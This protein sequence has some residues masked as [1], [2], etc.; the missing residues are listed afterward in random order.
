MPHSPSTFEIAIRSPTIESHFYPNVHLHV[1]AFARNVHLYV[2]AFSRNGRTSDRG[3][4]RPRF[5][6]FR[7]R[8]QRRL[9]PGNTL[10]CPSRSRLGSRSASS[11]QSAGSDLSKW[12]NCHSTMNSRTPVIQGFSL[13]IMRDRSGQDSS[14]C[15]RPPQNPARTPAAR[16]HMHR[17]PQG[18]GAESSNRRQDRQR[19]PST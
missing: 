16:R 17:L 12:P 8:T 7:L 19:C 1:L 9:R 2:L 10:E 13:E 6:L 18:L 14:P 15:S 4:R 5:F 11:F 3:M